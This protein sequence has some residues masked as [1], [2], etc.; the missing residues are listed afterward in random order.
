MAQKNWINIWKK[1]NLEPN[2]IPYIHEMN[3][4]PNIKAKTIK[5]RGNKKKSVFANFYRKDIFR[6]KGVLTAKQKH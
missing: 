2:L 3:Y 1:I 4:Q 5:G 6:N